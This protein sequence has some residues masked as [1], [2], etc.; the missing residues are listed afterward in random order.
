MSIFNPDS[1]LQQETTQATEAKYTPIP[2]AEYRATV[3]DVTSGLSSKK[4]VPFLNV[5]F[6]IHDENLRKQLGMEHVRVNMNLWLDLTETG[7]IEVGPNKNVKLGKLREALGQNQSGQAWSPLMMK[8]KGPVV[9]LVSQ[10]KD[11]NDP[12]VVYND[13]KRVTKG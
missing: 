3:D 10:R 8:G 7:A 9:I 13:V 11:E 1:F 2:E 12:E 5:T 4:S 6:E